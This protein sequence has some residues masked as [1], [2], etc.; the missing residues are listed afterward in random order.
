[1]VKSSTGANIRT[2]LI[3]ILGD[4]TR[5]IDAIRYHN[6]SQPTFSPNTLFMHRHINKLCCWRGI[7]DF[8]WSAC[9][10]LT[11]PF[12]RGFKS[13][14]ALFSLVKH[15]HENIH[16]ILTPPKHPKEVFHPTV[17]SFTVIIYI[18]TRQIHTELSTSIYVKW[19]HW[20]FVFGLF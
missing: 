17:Y 20:T 12:S 6:D 2:N 10:V 15:S 7:S 3:I 4:V 11:I 13:S 18:S 19:H 8:I 1:M 14:L 16:A 9:K 5:L